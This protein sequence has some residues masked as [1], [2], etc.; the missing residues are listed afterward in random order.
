MNL[1]FGLQLHYYNGL[2]LYPTEFLRDNAITTFGFASMSEALLRAIHH[3]FTW[4]AVPCQIEERASGTSKALSGNNLKSV[5]GTVLSA[6]SGL[7]VCA[8]DEGPHSRLGSGRLA[9]PRP[10]DRGRRRRG[11]P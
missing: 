7:C 6:L 11:H 3:G 2:T 4:M 8:L 1:L 9:R 10:P 5:V